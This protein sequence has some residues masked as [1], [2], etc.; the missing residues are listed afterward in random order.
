MQGISQRA[1]VLFSESSFRYSEIQ[2]QPPLKPP[3]LLATDPA[4][5]HSADRGL[6]LTHG[7]W[8]GGETRGKLAAE[9]RIQSGVLEDGCG[10]EGVAVR[11]GAGSLG[12]ESQLRLGWGTERRPEGG[13]E[14]VSGPLWIESW[15][16]MEGVRRRAALQAVSGLLTKRSEVD[17]G[18]RGA[19]QHIIAS[20]RCCQRARRAAATKRCDCAELQ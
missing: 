17:G 18:P 11:A 15:N 6:G 5:E 19:S 1:A 4:A 9:T 20:K 12:A 3:A 2:V 10:E 16:R 14:G 13:L 7:V 8:Q